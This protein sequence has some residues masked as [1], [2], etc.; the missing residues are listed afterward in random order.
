MPKNKGEN[1]MNNDE[2]WNSLFDEMNDEPENFNDDNYDKEV[3]FAEPDVKEPIKE[4]KQKMKVY[5]VGDKKD[6]DAELLDFARELKGSLNSSTAKKILRNFTDLP[7]VIAYH[8]GFSTIYIT[9]DIEL[10]LNTR[11]VRGR[12]GSTYNAEN[13]RSTLVDWFEEI[14]FK[15]TQNNTTIVRGV[16]E[17]LAGENKSISYYDDLKETVKKYGK[18]NPDIYKYVMVDWLGAKDEKYTYDWLKLVLSSIN[19]NQMY[20]GNP[21]K[22]H[23]SPYQFVIQGVQGVGKSILVQ[24]ISDG[25]NFTF[26]PEVPERDLGIAMA[27][28]LVIDMDDMAASGKKN[29][30]DT[31]KQKITQS[32]VRRRKMREDDTIEELNRAVWIGSTNRSN[33]FK[34]TT[35]NRRS[36]PINVGTDMTKENSNHLGRVKYKKYYYDTV[37]YDLW[38]TFLTDMSN[39]LIN[40][41]FEFEGESNNSRM[42]YVADYS[43]PI[44]VVSDL[45]DMLNKDVPVNLYD[46]DK[47]DVISY[48][49]DG[50]YFRGDQN[51]IKL[52]TEDDNSIK[53][54]EMSVISSSYL[55]KSLK[56]NNKFVRSADIKDIMYD[57]GYKET[58]KDVRGYVKK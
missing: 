43:A 22:Y 38:Y 56:V 9:E 5:K 1:D 2:N 29:S 45:K 12:I 32:V 31:L 51:T 46:F 8:K 3:F 27:G 19:H 24:G 17:D 48:L 4:E 11:L 30:V 16:L 37:F 57:L 41:Q 34:D 15:N 54:S 44:E 26:T 18:Y 7:R 53:F 35:G 47:E 52:A 36:F 10:P 13:K 33:I 6:V 23:P 28:Q 14:G 20:N 49:T 21:S 55:L 42:M 39:G 58:R 25:H 50:D 40:E